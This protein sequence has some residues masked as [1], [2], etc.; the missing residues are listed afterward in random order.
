MKGLVTTVGVETKMG[1][2]NGWQGERIGSD[3]AVSCCEQ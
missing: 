3:L 2:G 1:M